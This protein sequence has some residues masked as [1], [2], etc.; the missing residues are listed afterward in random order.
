[1]VAD[2]LADHDFARADEP[3]EFVLPP[4]RAPSVPGHIEVA[5]R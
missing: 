2:L 5:V 3:G 4:G 1:M